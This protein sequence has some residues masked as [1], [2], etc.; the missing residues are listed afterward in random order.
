MEKFNVVRPKKYK[1]GQE[2]KTAWL[3]VGT[4]TKFDNGN[5]I[6]EMNDRE[7]SYNI[8]PFKKKDDFSDV[9]F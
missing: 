8:F 6:L 4:I 2:E 9:P 7:E 5:Q 3:P 1:A